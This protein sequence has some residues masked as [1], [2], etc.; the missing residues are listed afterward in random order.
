MT[1]YHTYYKYYKEF[2]KA[3]PSFEERLKN[4]R[5]R[6]LNRLTRTS[7]SPVEQ[8]INP[9]HQKTAPVKQEVLPK[10]SPAQ[11]AVEGMTGL[12]AVKDVEDYSNMERVKGKNAWLK[13]L[14]Y[15]FTPEGEMRPSRAHNMI[16]AKAEGSKIVGL[17][18][19]HPNQEQIH[20]MNDPN[21]L[22]FKEQFLPNEDMNAFFDL[23]M[24]MPAI[25]NS[26]GKVDPKTLDVALKEMKQEIEQ[27][28]PMER[29]L[30][31][32]MRERDST[33]EQMPEEN[34]GGVLSQRSFL[35]PI[36]SS[37]KKE[38]PLLDFVLSRKKNR[39][40]EDIFSRFDK[41]Y[42]ME[43]SKEKRVAIDDLIKNLGYMKYTLANPDVFAEKNIYNELYSKKKSE[44]G[45]K[46]KLSV[47]ASDLE[48]KEEKAK[49]KKLDKYMNDLKSQ[50]DNR[51]EIA[52]KGKEIIEQLQEEAR[53]LIPENV[54][55]PKKQE[56]MEAISS[57][58][59]PHA[60]VIKEMFPGEGKTSFA[61]MITDHIAKDVPVEIQNDPEKLKKKA[62]SIV[63][64]MKRFSGD[65]LPKALDVMKLIEKNNYK[66]G[67][68][69]GATKFNIADSK[70]GE[71]I[72]P[73]LITSSKNTD[74]IYK[75]K[76][77]TLGMNN[78]Y[79]GGIGN[80]WVSIP[81]VP[82]E[83]KTKE[84]IF[85]QVPRVDYE[86]LNKQ[87][88]TFNE[89]VL[90]KM[91][92][93]KDQDAIAA[94]NQ[95]LEN[96]KAVQGKSKVPKLNLIPE[97]TNKPEVKK[98]EV[99]KPEIKASKGKKKSPKPTIDKKPSAP[100]NLRRVR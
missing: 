10:T 7:D 15:G 26:K 76:D 48:I 41:I 36:R 22:A 51:E 54:E 42:S 45:I 85:N 25:Q 57:S 5:E 70:S 1:S 19:K 73:K 27:R 43:D 49:H 59:T 13:M 35:Q 82:I 61:D 95:M 87:I 94:A 96:I 40:F 32:W 93:L 80:K 16:D 69:T 56:I 68:I 2:A 20:L 67:D 60:V 92:N 4:I 98:P 50:I 88:E 21:I 99:K 64:S 52:N 23:L 74:L 63:N 30:E 81:I 6:R 33:K 34:T 90:P 8:R 78:I 55:D 14:G 12:S 65:S 28:K 9:S 89:F 31:A 75:K 18:E 62:Y 37:L 24:L 97:K 66:I 29:Q 84:E 100:S 39:T 58:K 38:Y 91:R 72:V 47:N 83:G 46:D 44:L 77:G 11:E 79:V 3:D 53:K 17:P 86:R 71:Y